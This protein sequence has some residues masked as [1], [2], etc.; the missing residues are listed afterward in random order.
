M[1]KCREQWDRAQEALQTHADLWERVRVFVADF[2]AEQVGPGPHTRRPSVALRLPA[3]G[4]HPARLVLRPAWCNTGK[5]PTPGVVEAEL[6]TEQLKVS[7][8]LF[9]C[10]ELTV[11]IRT[12]GC[13]LTRAYLSRLG[14]LLSRSAAAAERF[15]ADPMGTFAGSAGNCCI[16]G[17]GLSD[18]V[19][20]GR[21][22]GPECHKTAEYFTRLVYHEKKGE[23]TARLAASS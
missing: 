1:S 22:I 6:V 3:T 4:E 15:L 19:S 12:T 9:P 8:K 7:G 18:P 10:R 16:C 23:Q 11:S 21:G 5:C 14:E 20:R 13:R 17:K 2:F